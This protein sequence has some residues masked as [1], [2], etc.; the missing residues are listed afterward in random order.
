MM[1]LGLV[2]L[3]AV[4]VF[5]EKKG[6]KTG[7]QAEPA[8]GKSIWEIP[9]WQG[10]NRTPG[11]QQ[12]PAARPENPTTGSG[13]AGALIPRPDPDGSPAP[14]L[15]ADSLESDRPPDPGELAVPVLCYHQ[16]FAAD[17]EANPYNVS[18]AKLEAQLSYL[19]GQGYTAIGLDDLYYFLNGK[20]VRQLPARPIILTFDDGIK[21]VRTEVAA[22][23]EKYD[24]TGVLFVYPG[25]FEGDADVYLRPAQI[26][27]LVASGRFE[28]GSHTLDHSLLPRQRRPEIRRQLEQ[29]RRRLERELGIAVQDLSYPFGL[30]DRAVMEEARAAGYRM[31]F[32]VNMGRSRPGMNL[33]ALPRI[34]ITADTDLERFAASLRLYSPAAVELAPPDGS[35]VKAGMAV[36]IKIEAAQPGTVEARLGGTGLDLAN[37]GGTYRGV[38][39]PVAS[40]SGFLPLTIRGRTRDGR[41]FF[42]QFL[43]IKK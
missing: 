4:A 34:M 3:A 13:S 14:V 12:A 22:L 42:R 7:K 23:L 27:E 6:R 26:K 11:T 38:L 1:L 10:P 40:A 39:P 43:Y 15:P 36:R 17:G 28:V 19:R 33:Y 35:R 30:Y 9:G 5:G 29:S 37:E 20:G 25:A 41:A 32:T 31:A 24:F 2:L 21:S 8:P 16:N 18:P